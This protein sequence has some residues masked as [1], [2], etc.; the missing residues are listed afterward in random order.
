MARHDLALAGCRPEPLSNYL[1]ALGVLRLV[2]EQKDKQAMG[3]WKDDTFHLVSDMDETALVD[4]FV[5]KYHP[6][7]IIA[8]WNGG[9]GFYEQ[10]NQS[11]INEIEKST[12][13]RLT[14]YR[15]TIQTAKSVL[16]RLS[17]TKKPIEKSKSI[18][19]EAL[20]ASLS[21][22]AVDWIDTVVR[23]VDGESKF[24][25]LLGT[26]G[27]D[28]RLEFTNNFMQRLCECINFETGVPTAKTV[29]WLNNSLLGDMAKLPNVKIGQFNSS[30][31]G[32]SNAETGFESKSLVNPWDYILLLEGAVAMSSGITRRL[33]SGNS[34]HLNAPFTVKPIGAGYG[35]SSV[36]ES[37]GRGEMW[38]PIWTRPTKYLAIAAMMA[39]GRGKVHGKDAKD[40]VDFALA[41]STLGVDRGVDAFQ[42]YSI[43]MRN[44]KSYFA[45]SLGQYGAV[46]NPNASLVSDID[47]WRSEIRKHMKDAPASINRSLRILEDSIFQICG[48]GAASPRE[49]Q[50]V[51]INLGRLESSIA[52][53]AKWRSKSRLRPIQPLEGDWM[54]AADDGSPEFRLA[55]CLASL[56]GR[57]RGSKGARDIG[58]RSNVEPVDT[59]GRVMWERGRTTLI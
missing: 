53:S 4:F 25:P 38:L 18:L 31:A 2:S 12:L 43:Q 10:D 50:Q 9:S 1:K 40:A 11:A 22:S 14:T 7:P 54:D 20:R 35:S 33:E 29:P 52:K 32:G 28:G 6:T 26:G 58:I 36:S 8:P 45:L 41:A 15:A 23:L 46:Y 57:Y 55:A 59:R 49:I 13:S 37:N 42:R 24:P 21:D 19:I 44:G 17:V 3:Y 30:A 51:L 48:M 56:H 16:R 34:S 47:S 39:E 5:N 27:N